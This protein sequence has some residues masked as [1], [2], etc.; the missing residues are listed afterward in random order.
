MLD[1]STYQE[2]TGDLDF[3]EFNFEVLTVFV[4]E[5]IAHTVWILAFEIQKPAR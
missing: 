3:F 4:N 1:N 2:T 5:R